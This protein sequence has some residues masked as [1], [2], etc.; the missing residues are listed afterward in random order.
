MSEVELRVFGVR[1]HG[2]GS[3]RALRA[4]LAAFAPD[5]VLVEGPPDADEL[6]PWLTHPALALP[7][8]LLVYRPDEPRRATFY[9]FAVFSPEYQAL[10]HA[11]TQGV[12]VGFMDLPRRHMLA[13]AVPPAMP[14]AEMF[15]QL[16]AAAGHE[17]YEPWWNEAV[18]QRQQPGELFDAVLEMATTLRG[19]P[20]SLPASSATDAQHLAAAR[21]ASM[22]QRIRRAAADGYRR[23][24]AVC[25][26][27]H[28]P[29]LTD[30]LQ[31]PAA[32]DDDL[33][34]DLPAIAV[35][36]TWVPWTY[37][38]MTQ[39][40]GYGAGVASPGWYGHLWAVAEP[41]RPV[42]EGWGEGDELRPS[43]SSAQGE[44]DQKEGEFSRRVATGWLAKAGRLL[45]EEG[46]D[47]SPGHLIEA[48][49]LAEA[50]AALRGRPFPAL[51]ELNEAAQAVL[52][53]GDAEPMGL[54]RRRLVVG[55]R[56]GIVPPDVPA[57]PLQHDLRAQQIR[58][59]LS[60]EPEPSPLLLDLRQETDLARSR[61]LHRLTLVDIPWGTHA[62]AKG[63]S[64]GTFAELWQLQWRPDLALR[65]VEAAMW[66]NTVRDA[67]TARAADLAERLGELPALIG[68]IDR[69]VLADL[70]EAIPAVLARIEA[71]SATGADVGHMLAALPP[72]AQTLRYGGLR[73]SSEHLAQ[74]RRVFD[75]LLTRACLALP[76]ACAALDGDAAGDMAEQLAAAAPAAHLVAEPR[77]AERWVEALLALAD[78]RGIHPTVA[79]RA[80]RLL[81]EAAAQPPASIGPRLARALGGGTA[82]DVRYAADWLDGLLR[83]SG[84]LLVHDRALWAEVD[85][86]LSALPGERF[87]EVLP[88][89]RRT[90]SD[91]PEGVREQL[92]RQLERRGAGR[93]AAGPPADFDPARAAAVLPVVARLLGVPWTGEAR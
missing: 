34:R 93:R 51:D 33:L 28:A 53:G 41:P 15:N 70:P 58:L 3:A 90:F 42:G 31:Q 81:H 29:A 9:P 78:R 8:A 21:E 20:A 16:A 5:C 47:T 73:H 26:A 83:D 22:R 71:L 7:V 12:A 4:A 88:L 32:P 59:R 30:T 19:S 84:L 11:L 50:L 2:P 40:G 24:A 64:A 14:S 27:W 49:R 43:P 35:A 46:F 57:V 36:A 68:L 75:H 17:G 13:A 18:E 87:V 92:R 76:R 63:Q 82:D 10:R 62:P 55:E 61:L 91:Y 52:C 23:I 56:M 6:I 39:A 48:V 60:P 72:L 85:G 1:H 67:A 86:W 80:T 45:R 65:V 25:G 77:A 54:I 89:L 38:R 69:A 66:G 74:L 37:S 79:G 44:G